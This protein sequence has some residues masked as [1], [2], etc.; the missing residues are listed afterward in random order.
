[1][2]EMG[3]FDSFKPTLIKLLSVTEVLLVTHWTPKSLVLSRTPTSCRLCAETAALGSVALVCF[4][5]FL[6]RHRHSQLTYKCDSPFGRLSKSDWVQF[7]PV[8]SRHRNCIFNSSNLF[9]SW[10]KI[11]FNKK[12]EILVSKT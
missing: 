8:N 2:I 1:M 9:H 5:L 11:K 6:L 10:Q 4:L 12:K 3:A 7:P